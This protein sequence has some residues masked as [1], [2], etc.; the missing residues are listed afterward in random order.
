M[1]ARLSSII[2][3]TEWNRPGKERSRVQ[4][5]SEMVVVAAAAARCVAVKPLPLAL[6]HHSRPVSSS[7]L[8]RLPRTASARSPRSASCS[9]SA[10]PPPPL[11]FVAVASMDAPPQGYRTNVG[12]CLADPSLTKIFSASRL[13]IPSAWQM[14]QGG[15]DAG[16][17]PRAA[18][19]RELRE[20]TGVTSAEIVAEA[21]NWLTYDFPPDVRDKL[22]A[23]WGTDWKGQAQ[24]W[25]LFRLTGNDDEINLNGDGSEKPEFGEWTWMTP[26][27]VIEKAVEFKKPVYEEALKHFAPYL[28]SDPAASS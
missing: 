2:H 22:N 16:E 5:E 1:E 7:A 9:T 25:F 27:E 4:S 3:G 17:E 10:P 18:A 15:I 6:V 26:Q 12:I 8:L 20:E 24:K 23:R 11:P 21:P 19:F 14:P 13:D 28:Q